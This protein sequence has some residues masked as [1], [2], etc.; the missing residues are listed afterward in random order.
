MPLTPRHIPASAPRVGLVTGGRQAFNAVAEPSAT[1]D[2]P[3]D[4]AAHRPERSASPGSRDE[5]DSGPAPSAEGERMPLPGEC[6]F[7]LFL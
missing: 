4:M 3:P 7:G 1:A 2:S 6:L 5:V